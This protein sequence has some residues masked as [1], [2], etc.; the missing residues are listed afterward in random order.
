[1]VNT[2]HRNKQEVAETP[3]G[4]N[5]T[6]YRFSVLTITGSLLAT[7]LPVLKRLFSTSNSKILKKGPV[8]SARLSQMLLLFCFMPMWK[9]NFTLFN[10]LIGLFQF[11]NLKVQSLV[12]FLLNHT[13]S[14]F[15]QDLLR[16]YFLITGWFRRG[17]MEEMLLNEWHPKNEWYWWKKLLRNQINWLKSCSGNWTENGTRS[18]KKTMVIITNIDQCSEKISGQWAHIFNFA[19]IMRATVRAPL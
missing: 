6:I 2:N 14:G 18:S 17:V 15:T 1:M 10:C 4:R 13:R 19:R 8:L 9:L 12:I 11:E 3:R 7:G 5:G 16:I